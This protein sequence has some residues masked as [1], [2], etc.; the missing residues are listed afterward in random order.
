MSQ[1]QIQKVNWWHERLADLMIAHPDHT[2]QQIAAKLNKTPAWVS[3]IKN[4]DAF[5]DYWRKRS[6]VHSQEVTNGIKAKGYAAAELALDKLTEKLEG[7]EADLM[8]TE[9]LLNVVDVTMRRFGYDS[10]KNQPPV[11]NFNLGSV[12]PEQLAAARA[13]LRQTG[14]VQELKALPSPDEVVDDSTSDPK[15]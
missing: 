12:T 10:S 14:E 5:I 11:F 9:T 7:P 6:G 2:L 4:S 13:R 3:V 15:K 8:T 1:V